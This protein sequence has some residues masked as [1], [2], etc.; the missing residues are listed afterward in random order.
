MSFGWNQA[1]RPGSIANGTLFAASEECDCVASV[2]MRRRWNFA[3]IRLP[4]IADPGMREW[5]RPI[6]GETNATPPELGHMSEFGRVGHD[7]GRSCR[8]R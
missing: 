3:S 7:Q 5:W 6:N 4:R 1:P 2:A 8:G